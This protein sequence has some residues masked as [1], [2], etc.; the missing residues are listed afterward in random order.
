MGF[1]HHPLNV[2]HALCYQDTVGPLSLYYSPTVASNYPT[3]LLCNA[4][5]LGETLAKAQR[6]FSFLRTSLVPSHLILLWASS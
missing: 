6:V 4:C 2:S 5:L 1:G 3:L